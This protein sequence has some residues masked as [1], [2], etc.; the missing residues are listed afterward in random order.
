M[1]VAG[2][3]IAP[4]VDDGHHGFVHH[5]FAPRALL[6]HALAMRKAPHAS[7]AKPAAAAKL[8]E[9]FHRVGALLV[10]NP[11]AVS[12]GIVACG[13]VGMSIIFVSAN[14]NDLNSIR[15]HGKP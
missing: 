6:L 15:H 4:G 11:L 9:L 5:I 2:R 13:L 10:I 8:R 7:V 12:V 3:Q 14:I 1:G